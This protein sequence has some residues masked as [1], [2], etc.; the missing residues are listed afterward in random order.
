MSAVDLRIA[1][2]LRRRGWLCFPRSEIVNFVYTRVAERPDLVK[3]ELWWRDEA[4]P[5]PVSGAACPSHGPHPHGGLTCLDCPVCRPS[6][7]DV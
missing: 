3:V 7:S 2:R 5:V 4:R 1:E 6:V